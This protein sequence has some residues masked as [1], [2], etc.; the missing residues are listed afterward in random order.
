MSDSNGKQPE[1]TPVMV[2]FKPQVHGNLHE[3]SATY[4][5]DTSNARD[6][7]FH[8]ALCILVQ[9]SDVYPQPADVQVSRFVKLLNVVHVVSVNAET[10][11]FSNRMQVTVTYLAVDMY[12]IPVLD[13]V[14]QFTDPKG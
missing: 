14:L 3:R 12:D 1:T 6:L 2:P 4:D 11:P 13:D 10:Q 5:F 9:P 8:R 7:A